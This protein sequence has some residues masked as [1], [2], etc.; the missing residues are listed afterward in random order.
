MPDRRRTFRLIALAAFLVLVAVVLWLADVTPVAVILLM[1]A[2]WGVAAVVEWFSWRE[3]QRQLPPRRPRWDAAGTTSSPGTG[4]APAVGSAGS[5]DS[6]PPADRD[7]GSAR[8]PEQDEAEP[9]FPPQP[10]PPE[11][12]ATMRSDG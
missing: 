10:V 4:G 2:A 11:R 6:T 1:L 3:E 8:R 12:P 7:V 9:E 5:T